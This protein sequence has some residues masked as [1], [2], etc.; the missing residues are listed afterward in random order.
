MLHHGLVHSEVPERL[1]KDLHAL[2]HFAEK[3]GVAHVAVKDSLDGHRGVTPSAQINVRALLV[4]G[5]RPSMLVPI[6]LLAVDALLRKW[7]AKVVIS[8]IPP[9]DAPA[10]LRC[11]DLAGTRGLWAPTSIPPEESTLIFLDLKELSDSL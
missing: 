9:E 2:F 4:G 1:L 7:S 6:E 10:I 5:A 8:R 11:T 3:R